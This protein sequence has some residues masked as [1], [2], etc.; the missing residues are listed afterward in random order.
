VVRVAAF[1]W[2]CPQHITSRYTRGEAEARSSRKAH[3]S[4]ISS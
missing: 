3:S 4:A 2:N 1:D